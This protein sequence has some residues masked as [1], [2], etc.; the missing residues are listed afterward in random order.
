MMQTLLRIVFLLNGCFFLL[1]GTAFFPAI[2]QSLF[3]IQAQSSLPSP[4]FWDLSR[5]LSVVRV[6][7]IVVGIFL[8][9]FGIFLVLIR[10]R[11]TI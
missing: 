9:G 2:S 8:T 3:H 11:W 7:F 10:K 1:V 4:S 5:V 6:I